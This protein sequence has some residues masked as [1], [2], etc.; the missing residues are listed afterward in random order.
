MLNKIIEIIETIIYCR[1]S[2]ERQVIDGNGIKSQET[3]CR[4]Y[5]KA[6]G[7]KVVKVFRDEGISGNLFDRPAMIDLI[8]FLDKNVNKKYVVIF[9]DLSRFSRNLA[10]HIKLKSEIIGRGSSLECPN[11]KFEDSPEGE[12][13]EN[14]IAAKAQLDRQQNRRQVIQKMLARA[15]DGYWPFGPPP[16]MVNTRAS[17]K[18]KLLT[19]KE[20]LASVIKTS[21]EAY[22]NDKINTYEEFVVFIRNAA[23]K[24]GIHRKFSKDAAYRML[25]NPLYAGY[26]EYRKKT[27]HWE[28]NISFRKAQHEG[29]ISLKTYQV[30]QDKLH[31]KAKPRL[32]ADYSLDFPLRGFVVCSECRRRLTGSWNTGRS[33]KRYANYSCK[34]KGCKWKGKAINK[35][36]IE[37]DFTLL[38][39]SIKPDKE[40]LQLAQKI[41]SDAWEDRRIYYIEQQKRV[42]G[43]KKLLQDQAAKLAERVT[44]TNNEDLIALY[45]KEMSKITEKMKTIP[46]AEPSFEYSTEEF[47]TALN[48]G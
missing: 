32:R 22:A 45:E 3:N 18:G 1:V 19:A 10:V 34:T 43:E 21:L 4:A 8:N 29:I 48:T 42:D 35:S 11:F 12:F 46:P 28:W 40:F 20:P 25:S 26:I 13:I 41:F 7:Y 2:S 14:V 6:K 9:D 36:K 27:E 31:G 39:K 23:A 37:S 47:G 5:A 30:I 33:K 15:E 17:S 16:G 44:K 24:K 38:L